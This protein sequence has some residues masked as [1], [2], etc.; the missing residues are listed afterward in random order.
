MT[1]VSSLMHNKRPNTFGKTLC[2]RSNKKVSYCKQIAV[3][4]RV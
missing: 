3:S 4:V 2:H 1:T